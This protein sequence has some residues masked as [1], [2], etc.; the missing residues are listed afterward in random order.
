MGYKDSRIGYDKNINYNN[1]KSGINF[2]QEN[3]PEK[4]EMIRNQYKPFACTTCSK[5]YGRL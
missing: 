3:H 4:I 5:F 1:N 2:C